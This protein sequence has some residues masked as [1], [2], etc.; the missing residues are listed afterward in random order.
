[1]R[2]KP[3]QASSV[4]AASIRMRAPTYCTVHCAQFALEKDKHG[5]NSAFYA[6]VVASLERETKSEL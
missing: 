4:L 5:M 2:L 6:I 3:S 1:M